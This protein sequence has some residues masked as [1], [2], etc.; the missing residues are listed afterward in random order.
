MLGWHAKWM[1]SL[2][3]LGVTLERGQGYGVG[4]QSA[5]TI[6]TPL[7]VRGGEVGFDAI[8]MKLELV[9]KGTEWPVGYP[10]WVLSEPP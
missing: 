3:A 7:E 8:A 1:E 10:R 2:Q 6:D 9:C 4:G 5:T